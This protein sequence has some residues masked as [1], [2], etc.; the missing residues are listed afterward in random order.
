MSGEEGLVRFLAMTRTLVCSYY[1]AGLLVSTP[2]NQDCFLGR[3]E[4]SE[5][6][7]SHSLLCIILSSSLQRRD[8]GLNYTQQHSPSGCIISAEIGVT[9]RY[10]EP[11][12]EARKCEK[13]EGSPGFFGIQADVEYSDS[14]SISD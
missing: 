14:I 7:V 10:G 13:V 11:G 12:R 4:G 6:D 2:Y 3:S 5:P 8:H 1:P 9:R